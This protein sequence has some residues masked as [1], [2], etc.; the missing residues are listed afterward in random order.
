MEIVKT[1]ESLDS[2]IMCVHRTVDTGEVFF[3]CHDGYEV[4]LLLDGTV[5]YY[6]EQTGHRLEHGSL[7]CVK[8]YDFHRR[9]VIS[10]DRAY[11]RITIN[12]SMDK[13]KHLSTDK[14]D[15][16]ECFHKNDG[17]F[18][19]DR[20]EVSK[21]VRISGKMMQCMLMSSYGDDVMAEN[22]MREIL[23]IINKSSQGEKT[24]E[25][26]NIMPTQISEIIAHIHW[27]ISEKITVEMLAEEF[28]Y[29]PAHISRLFKKITGLTISQYITQKKI[30]LA[31]KYLEEGNPPSEVCYLVGFGNYSHFSRTF[32]K[33]VG[34]SPQK[35]QK[36]S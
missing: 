17:V 13:M 20:E 22:Y 35:Y 15:L 2:E 8:P 10:K 6:I 5:N 33:N 28:H 19:L 1:F 25:M 24:I 9:E 36:G 32:M 34:I 26:P 27:H 29:S 16:S 31:K 21:F 30:M 3:H 12:I 18:M 4:L 11:D 14:T 23:V 7:V